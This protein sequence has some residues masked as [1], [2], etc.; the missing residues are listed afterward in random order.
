ASTPKAITVRLKCQLQGVNGTP[1][2]T[3]VKCTSLNGWF[4]GRLDWVS[5]GV[6]LFQENGPFVGIQGGTD[7]V[8][9]YA[10]GNGSDATFQAVYE[11]PKTSVL[12]APDLT[13]RLYTVANGAATL[14]NTQR[15]APVASA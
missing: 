7:E 6:V 1:D 2:G 3:T 14:V 15:Y 8:L 4:D 10:D 5:G 11:D 12:S 9:I 13:L